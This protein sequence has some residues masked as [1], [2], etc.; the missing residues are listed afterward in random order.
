[1]FWKAT[2]FEKLQ[3]DFQHA[4]TRIHTL[5]TEKTKSTAQLNQLENLAQTV[6][7]AYGITP[8]SADMSPMMDEDDN[9]A[10]SIK[11]SIQEFNILK[12][13]NIAR[14]YHRYAHPFQTHVLP[15][16]W[17]VQGVVRSSFGSRTDPFSGEGAFHSGVD[18]SAS[19]GTPVHVTA[20][21][22]VDIVTSSGRY[23][24]LLVVDHGGGIQT[25]YAHLSQF[26]VVPGQEVRRN[27]VVPLRAEQVA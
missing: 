17:P 20:D 22:V 8:T 3:A 12:T 25:Y 13:A 21:G 10:A 16:L 9:S 14:I 1:M 26:L 2:Q 4:R 6:S 15:S 19:V 23:G 7:V 18:L 11:E 24:R 27:E 5:E